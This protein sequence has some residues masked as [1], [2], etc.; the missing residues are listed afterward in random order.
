MPWP[1]QLPIAN[2]GEYQL[3]WT[4]G[5][6]S[7]KLSFVTVGAPPA[8]LVDA[9]QLLIDKG[10]QNQLDLLIESAGESD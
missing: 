1:S 5:G 7:S 3:D 6:D 2:G 8:D 4:G 9:A 10:C